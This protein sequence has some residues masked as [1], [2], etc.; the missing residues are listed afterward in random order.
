MIR[1]EITT[2]SPWGRAYYRALA[3]GYDHGYAA[4][5][6]DKAQERADRK[7]NLTTTKHRRATAD[8]G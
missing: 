8:G 1:A 6:A 5:A 4:W 7:A 3:K 2:E